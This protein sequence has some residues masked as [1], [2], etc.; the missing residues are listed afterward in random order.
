M[1]L[2]IS[3][4]DTG[5]LKEPLTA[6]NCVFGP[7][8]SSV[9]AGASVTNNAVINNNEDKSGDFINQL[10]DHQAYLLMG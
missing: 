9:G 7:T 3:T 4:Y 5:A 1:P 6:I 8:S 2:T 10:K